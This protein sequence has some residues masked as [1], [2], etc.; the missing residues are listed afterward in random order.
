[1]GVVIRWLSRGVVVGVLTAVFLCLGIVGCSY[2]LMRQTDLAAYDRPAGAIDV[3]DRLAALAGPDGQIDPVAAAA[4]FDAVAPRLA[5]TQIIVVP[6]Y[7][8]D[9]FRWLRARGV[10]DYFMDQQ[11]WLAARGLTVTLADGDTEATVAENGRRLAGL[12]AGGDRP[13]CFVSHS[14]GGLEVLD[15]LLRLTPDQR[16]RV[17]C[18]IAMQAPFGG[19]PFAD[20]VVDTPLL[21]PLI[22]GMSWVLGGSGDAVVDLGTPVRRAW[23]AQNDAAIAGL[24]AEIPVLAVTTRLLPRD[25]WRAWSPFAGGRYWMDAHGIPSDGVVPTRS[26]ILPHARFVRIEGLDHGDVMDGDRPWSPILSD[27]TALIAALFAI[28]MGE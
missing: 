28:V 22:D 8:Y 2:V 7:L 23:M 17:R 14:K 4:A 27:D 19:S 11:R 24:V 15:A 1:M 20:M 3:T 18:W 26:A 25:D 10:G 13:V 21:H 12:V 9:Q 6:S 5:G 16:A